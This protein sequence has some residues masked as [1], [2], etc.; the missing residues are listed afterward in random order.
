MYK[1][2][3]L[4]ILILHTITLGSIVLGQASWFVS[5]AHILSLFIIPGWL[6]THILF[7]SRQRIDLETRVILTII[8]GSV[9]V[10][11]ETSGL[12]VGKVV[13]NSRNL[14]ILGFFVTWVMV[15]WIFLEAKILPRQDKARIG[16]KPSMFYA[17][18]LFVPMLLLF[19]W[20]HKPIT[21]EPFT[22]FYIQRAEPR[23][24]A[25][26]GY[27]KIGELH[28]INH[29]NAL[30]TY[31]IKCFDGTGEEKILTTKTLQ[32]GESWLGAIL[33]PVTYPPTDFVKTQLNLYRLQDVSA[34]LWLE[35]RATDCEMYLDN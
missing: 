10:I 2:S 32:P 16:L 26:D 21:S 14:S 34:Y 27:I 23:V 4:P 11:L 6:L 15:F 8:A 3:I 33:L 19:I 22:E 9:I 12:L 30:Q 24:E 1:T 28:L 29:G 35:V 17:S 25:E 13:I 31:Q 7:D 20:A 5:A 18:V